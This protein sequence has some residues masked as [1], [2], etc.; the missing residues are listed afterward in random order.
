MILFDLEA[1]LRAPDSSTEESTE[2]FRPHLAVSK[3]FSEVRPLQREL[4]RIADAAELLQ[5][6][7]EFG[8]VL[9]ALGAFHA[10]VKDLTRLIDPMR[11]FRNRLQQIAPLEILD[12]ELVRFA[13]EFGASFKRLA[14][15]LEAAETVQERLVQLAA[16]FEPAKSL[17]AEFSTLAKSFAPEPGNP[18][19]QPYRSNSNSAGNETAL[20]HLRSSHIASKLG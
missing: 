17:R 19:R 11:D 13:A 1:A 15:S 3:V 10:K 5:K 14:D 2:P 6:L 9:G 7:S 12:Q 16:V 8:E 4:A 18:E 20:K